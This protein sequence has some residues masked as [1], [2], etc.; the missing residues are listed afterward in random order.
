[1]IRRSDDLPAVLM[2][3]RLRDPG[4]AG[5]AADG[6]VRGLGLPWPPE[7]QVPVAGDP[8]RGIGRIPLAACWSRIQSSRQG[9]AGATNDEEP[10]PLD[11]PN[12]DDFRWRPLP[13]QE[14]SLSPGQALGL[15]V[16]ACRREV[17][18]T[19]GPTVLIAPCSLD[20]GMQQYVLDACGSNTHILPRSIAIAL[21]WLS[22]DAAASTLLQ[23]RE[24]GEIGHVAV[25]VCG[26]D[27]WEM[28][29][30]PI[31][32]RDRPEGRVLLPVRLTPS[33]G[34]SLGVNGLQ[35]A[36]GRQ[37]TDSRGVLHD[38]WREVI[39][40]PSSIA[41]DNLVSTDELIAQAP[42][43][44]RSS[45]VH[46]WLG[47]EGIGRGPIANRV[48]QMYNERIRATGIKSQLCAILASGSWSESMCA[49]ASIASRMA[50]DLDRSTK[51]IIM[52]VDSAIRGADAFLKR[53]VQG[54][55]AYLE[56]LIPVSIH[57]Q[58]RL[59]GRLQDAW[60]PLTRQERPLRLPAGE[61]FAPD[62]IT[63]FGVEA[64]KKDLDLTLRRP[65]ISGQT[66]FD[67]RGVTVG[68][69][70]A[71]DKREPV[72]ITTRIRPGQGYAQ[73]TVNGQH[74]KGISAFLNWR[75]LARTEKPTPKKI[76]YPP[77]TARITPSPERWEQANQLIVKL[78]SGE[79]KSVIDDLITLASKW[80]ESSFIAVHGQGNVSDEDIFAYYG[81][82]PCRD[83]AEYRSAIKGS[84]AIIRHLQGD[85]RQ[86]KDKAFRMA[87]WMYDL[88]PK[89][90]VAKF[91]GHFQN[92]NH[93]IEK[94]DLHVAA[95]T[96][97]AD[98]HISVFWRRMASE[99]LNNSHIGLYPMAFDWLRPVRNL[100]MFR[101]GALGS[102]IIEE[103]DIKR[104]SAFVCQ[105][106]IDVLKPSISDSFSIHKANDVANIRNQA[107]RTLPFM[108]RR[109]AFEP[110]FFAPGTSEYALMKSSIEAASRVDLGTRK[111]EMAAY[112]GVTRKFLDNEATMD[113]VRSLVK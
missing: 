65:R 64:G 34:M 58:T 3:L 5:N 85:L 12:V 48:K 69:P 76:G 42:Q 101:E 82:F 86:N 27:G 49:G 96:F 50:A 1:M 113:D 66:D 105:C 81:L 61:E 103:S 9:K 13:D 28:D 26:L 88:A 111:D 87:A 35:V 59:G 93:S 2:P 29:V 68:F 108:L 11:A 25:L 90:M 97:S 38:A 102:S 80:T 74:N 72:V 110:S 15:A 77:V 46:N 70:V 78:S 112:L 54:Q 17:G 52:R 22:S 4:I 33:S 95:L 71:A 57:Y 37:L 21:A 14:I 43:V 109:K 63:G 75:E 89:D 19:Q 24:T 106:L 79:P 31:E 100:C 73:V 91:A 107:I 55:V 56:E 83:H 67:Y 36:L 62:P 44:I 47:D 20:E 45:V 8:F 92:K 16:D 23:S 32:V 10:S 104:I 6:H 39:T 41:G 51:R 18:P 98:S 94:I 60:E 84:E 30:V 53:H 99:L 40:R 7:A